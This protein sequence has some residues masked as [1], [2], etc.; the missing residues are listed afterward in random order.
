[1]GKVEKNRVKFQLDDVPDKGCLI[2]EDYIVC[3][4]EK[5]DIRIG[6]VD[7]SLKVTGMD[8][9]VAISKLTGDEK[10]AISKLAGMDEKA[11]I[12]IVTGMDEKAAISKLTGD[13][14][15]T[16]TLKDFGIKEKSKSN[17]K[18]H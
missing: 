9:K 4:D 7:E 15:A 10:A 13:E 16:A 1:M 8:E 12:F 11:T 18:S 17:K 3:K 6:K 14:K 5:G 2:V